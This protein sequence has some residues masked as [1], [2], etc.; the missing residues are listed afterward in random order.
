[1]VF[2]EYCAVGN[3]YLFTIA[4]VI[5]F[6]LA[7]VA[8]GVPTRINKKFALF[9][10]ITA[11]FYTLPQIYHGEYM[12][13]MKNIANYI[14][15]IFT[16]YLVF[17]TKEKA[18]D[19]LETII[20]ICVI[21]CVLGIVEATTHFNFWSIFQTTA[22]NGKMGPESYFRNDA[23]RIE[24]SF[25][26]CTPYSVFLIAVIG[27]INYKWRNCYKPRKR[28][29]ILA[30]SLCIINIYM[31]YTRASMILTIIIQLLFIL[32]YMKDAKKG[33]VVKILI[34]I[35]FA[36]FFIAFLPVGSLLSNNQ[37]LSFLLSIT[38]KTAGNN[39]NTTAYRFALLSVIPNLVKGREFLGL[40]LAN[41][42]SS[43]ALNINGVAS[44]N[45]S[46]D[47][48]FL[49]YY[50]RYGIIGILGVFWLYVGSIWT[51]KRRDI[52]NDLSQYFVYFKTIIGVYLISMLSVA[53]ITEYRVYILLIGIAF[54]M[55]A[56]SNVK[57][58]CES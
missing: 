14:L 54:S 57:A 27:L 43:F 18:E 17:N 41:L 28:K 46:I 8:K 22:M 32:F 21:M 47:N 3:V 49:W 55:F 2:P 6:F 33:R 24:Q 56:N 1:M 5:A 53:E 26:H 37:Y 30:Y 36:L 52:Q 13:T 31:T 23:Y 20:T 16:C 10:L 38:D 44:Q 48:N 42:P 51:L 11:A 4:S 19:F 50:I 35:N 9:I 45:T 7:I 40:G 15:P 58:S 25:G 12:Q 39:Y 29:Y 34:G